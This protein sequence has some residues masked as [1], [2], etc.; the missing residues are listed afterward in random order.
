MGELAN[1]PALQA[2]VRKSL[3][4]MQAEMLRAPPGTPVPQNMVNHARAGA[5]RFNLAKLVRSTEHSMCVLVKFPA[6]FKFI[7]CLGLN[8][9]FLFFAS[10]KIV[11]NG[12]RVPSQLVLGTRVA[13]RMAMQAGAL[14]PCHHLFHIKTAQQVNLSA[15]STE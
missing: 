14:A 5:G 4:G 12:I 1:V 13:M 6:F 8:S 15:C 2:F 11:V 3:V 7:C 10:G 9:A